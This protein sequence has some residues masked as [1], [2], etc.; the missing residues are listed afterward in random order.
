MKSLNLSNLT[1]DN[2]Q[3]VCET[4]MTEQGTLSPTVEIQGTCD[5]YVPSLRT[6]NQPDLLQR[7]ESKEEKYRCFQLHGITAHAQKKDV[8]KQYIVYLFQNHVLLMFRSKGKNIWLARSKRSK[9]VYARVSLQEK[10]REVRKVSSLAIRALYALGWDYG[11]VKVVVLPRQKLAV[12]DISPSPSV[13]E[14]VG[15][16]FSRA[17][18]RYIKGLPRLAISL[19]HILMGADP[20]FVM[21]RSDGQLVMASQYFPRFGQVGCDAIW[22]GRD[23]SVKPLVELR[24]KPSTDPRQLVI[25][26]YQGMLYASK[27][28]NDP[29]VRWL[30]GSLPHPNYPLGGHIHF[31]GIPLNF[32]LLRALDNYLALPLVLLEDSKGIKRRPRYGFLGDFRTQFHG[33]F[34]YRTLPSWLVSPTVTKGVLTAA[35]VIASSYPYLPKDYL[36]DFSMQK[37]YYHG[38]KTEIKKVLESLWNDLRNRKEYQQ[39]QEYLDNYYQMLTSGSAWDESRDIRV[40][41]KM[42]PYHR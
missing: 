25:R 8:L 34:E 39:Y 31:S 6:L 35:K 22:W 28:V 4:M 27:K 12:A 7:Y 30:S 41:W 3:Q 1:M 23:R 15:G 26:M 36:K 16:A 17:V 29:D 10:S 24:P 19:D 38:D 20:E 9:P 42:P 33:G 40:A 21:R 11:A 2:G 32:Q 37:A 13:N 18:Y 14:E 5:D